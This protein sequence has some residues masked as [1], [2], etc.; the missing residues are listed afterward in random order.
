MRDKKQKNAFDYPVFD[1]LSIEVR[2]N[3]YYLYTI[4]FSNKLFNKHT[5]KAR[6]LYTN[7][8]LYARE[9]HWN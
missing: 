7:N 4:E 3:K 8:V 1:L 6:R 5:N 9:K 2:A